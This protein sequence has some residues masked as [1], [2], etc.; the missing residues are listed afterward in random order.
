MSRTIVLRATQ[1]ANSHRITLSVAL[2]IEGHLIHIP[3]AHASAVNT[4]GCVLDETAARRVLAAAT[5]DVRNWH[6]A[7]TL[8]SER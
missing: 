3:S 5:K 7:P 8:W 6:V 2:E 1:R 4:I